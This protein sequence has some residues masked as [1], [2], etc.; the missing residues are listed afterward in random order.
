MAMIGLKRA[1]EL[2]GKNQ[3]TIHR[4]MTAGRLAFT[5]SDAGERLIDPAELHRVFPI[6]QDA[7]QVCNDAPVMPRNDTQLLEIK[8]ELTIAQNCIA[9]LKDRV[10][11]LEADKIDL[12][13]DRNRWRTQAEQSQLFLA[14]LRPKAEASVLAPASVPA[15][16]GAWVAVLAVLAGASICAAAGWWLLHFRPE[17]LATLK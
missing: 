11:M 1:A 4:A 9:S 14:D 7:L 6:L 8:T 13:E 3:S 10:A 5:T 15:R 17:I 2:T 16:T 12:R